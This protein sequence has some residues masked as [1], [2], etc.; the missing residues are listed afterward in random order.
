MKKVSRSPYKSPYHKPI[1]ISSGDI[2]LPRGSKIIKA[3]IHHSKEKP[4]RFLAK[5]HNSKA[6]RFVSYKEEGNALMRI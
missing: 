2:N 4:N 6:D 1:I 3:P 5:N